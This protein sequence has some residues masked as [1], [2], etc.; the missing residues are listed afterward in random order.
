MRLVLP[1]DPL[2]EFLVPMK[3]VYAQDHF[4]SL[5]SSHGVFYDIDNMGHVMNYIVKWG[6]FMV[7]NDSADMMR[8]QMGWTA[9]RNAEEAWANRSF[10][11]GTQ[12]VN[13]KG[14][15]VPAPSSPYVKGISKYFKPVG[16]Y[17]IWKECANQL[18]RPGLELHAFTLLAGFA[19]PLMCYTSTSGVTISLLGRSGAAK[20]G[21]MYAGLSVFG[22]PKDSSVFEATVFTHSQAQ[23]W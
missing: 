18:N 9:E 10:V 6:Q 21:A 15:V 7:S 14:E 20:T 16:S 23:Y 22:N 3:H 11:I 12:E 19:S 5:M 4:K 8:M 1:N 13:M 2:R 17:D